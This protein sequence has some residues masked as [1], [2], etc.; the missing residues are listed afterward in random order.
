MT[1]ELLTRIRKG[2]LDYQMKHS[3]T[4]EELAEHFI[5]SAAFSPHSSFKLD[6]VYGYKVL[7]EDDF[8]DIFIHECQTKSEAQE[9]FDELYPNGA[10]KEAKSYLMYEAP[11]DLI[12]KAG[13]Q[14][15][16]EI[17]LNGK[18]H[19]DVIKAIVS[20]GTKNVAGHI[21]SILNSLKDENETGVLNN[22]NPSS[23]SESISKTKSLQEDLENQRAEAVFSLLKGS[24]DVEKYIIPKA[25]WQDQEMSTKGESLV[26]PN[27]SKMPVELNKKGKK[28][29]GYSFLLEF[30]RFLSGKLGVNVGMVLAKVHPELAKNMGANPEWRESI[31][32]SPNSE[33]PSSSEDFNFGRH[34]GSNLREM[35]D[36]MAKK[37]FDV[38]PI[39]DKRSGGNCIGIV[40]LSDIVG[41]MSDMSF[42]LRNE[43]TVSV[44]QDYGAEGLI[45]SPP[46]Q[47]DA[48]TDLSVAGDILKHGNESL[49]VKFDP[50]HW[51]GNKDELEQIK[52]T[53]EPGYHIITPHDIIAYRL[54]VIA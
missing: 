26:Y 17:S 32:G 14:S 11:V 50:E 12:P 27:L 33:T 23:V 42:E 36:E 30:D 34:L 13:V 44:L 21:T 39:F 51:F 22:V 5:R 48:S 3:C 7:E 49:I 9:K 43:H 1:E 47:I 45:R 16:A 38:Q 10:S 24:S 53:L 25:S 52:Q 28:G 41:L 15:S 18:N 2:I 19:D 4:K 54:M 6:P 31:N 37:G 8:G 46:P 20:K 29:I 40:K 35:F